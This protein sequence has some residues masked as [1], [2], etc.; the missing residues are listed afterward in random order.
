M[1]GQS[2]YERWFRLKSSEA[3][4]DFRF[5]NCGSDRVESVFRNIVQSEKKIM[6][7]TE[8]DAQKLDPSFGSCMTRSI[9]PGR[10]LTTMQGVASR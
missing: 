2:L 8:I 9:R 7:D 5:L 3:V 1:F 6:G 10:S 4:F